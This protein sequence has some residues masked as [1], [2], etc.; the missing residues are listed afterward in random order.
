[1]FQA[2]CLPRYPHPRSLVPTQP[3]LMPSSFPSRRI[4][5]APTLRTS[6]TPP[7]LPYSAGRTR[8]RSLM[9]SQS[10]T[11]QCTPRTSRTSASFAKASR[12]ILYLLR[13][14]SS[15]QRPRAAVALLPRSAWLVTLTLSIKLGRKFSTRRPSRWCVLFSLFFSPRL[16]F[17]CCSCAKSLSANSAARPLMSRAI[18]LQIWPTAS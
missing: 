10:M 5:P 4:L 16:L 1:M 3:S 6:C 2:R 12:R 8:P 13:P 9:T 18:L 11:C 17:A 14:M 7:T 15:R